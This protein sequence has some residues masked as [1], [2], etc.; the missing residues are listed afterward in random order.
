[1]LQYGYYNNEPNIGR[2]HDPNAAN[3]NDFV[4]HAGLFGRID[5]LAQTLISFNENYNFLEQFKTKSLHR[6]KYGFDTVENTRDTLAGA[7][8]SDT[9]F[10]HLGFTGTSFWI[11]PIRQSGHIILSNATKKYWYSKKELT[12]NY[13]EIP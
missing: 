9:T 1:M 13:T 5:S 11:D 12:S 6:F 8:C 3:I 7:G 2:V 4:T 10:G